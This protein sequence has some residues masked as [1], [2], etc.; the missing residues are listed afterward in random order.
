MGERPHSYLPLTI[1]MGVRTARLRTPDKI[2]LA[3]GDRKL[4]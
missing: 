1:D 3:Q 2:A 4:S